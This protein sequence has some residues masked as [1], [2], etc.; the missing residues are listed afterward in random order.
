[1][2]NSRTY[3]ICGQ[4]ICIFATFI[5]MFPLVL[6]LMRSFQTSGIGNY[7]QVFQTINILPNF[8]TSVIVVFGTLL[9]VAVITSMAA[10]G[11]SKLEFRGKKTIYY[12]LLTGM[13]IPTSAL[14]FPLYQIVKRVG[15]INTP[16]SLILPY[17]ILNACFN[18]MV[19]KNYYD[20]LPNEL[21]EAAT[22]DGASKKNIFIRIMLPIAKP[23]LAF[24]LIQTFLSA[25]NELQM[26]MIFINDT[27][28]QPLSIVPLRFTQT[29]G[30]Q[31]FPLEV[32][33]AALVVCLLPVAIFYIFGSRFLIAG[34]TQGAIKG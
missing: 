18:L 21:I 29:A 1:M 30:V 5:F 3:N 8:T 15:L 31:G 24:V 12:M 27:A 11:F 34:L 6:M 19:L 22:I 14:I 26:G 9:I 4:I 20:A 16:F 32:M 33:Y 25:W 2:K 28:K 13:M 23:G 17:A 10:F 7:I